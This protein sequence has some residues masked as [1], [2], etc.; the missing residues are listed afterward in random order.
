[1]ILM[2]LYRFYYFIKGTDRFRRFESSHNLMLLSTFI[3]KNDCYQILYAWTTNKKHARLFKE[4]RTED[5]VCDA[6][7]IDETNQD[8]LEEFNSKR[9]EQLIEIHRFFHY[10]E[11]KKESFVEFPVTIGEANSVE[12]F[13]MEVIGERVMN[14]CK[15]PYLILKDEYIQ[16]LELFLYTSFYGVYWSDDNGLED[17]TSYNL[18]YDCT[19]PSGFSVSRILS[20]CDVFNVFTNVYEDM[21]RKKVTL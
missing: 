5:L 8:L 14:V 19:T 9:R 6:I 13:L 16:A 4:K 7:K 10:D 3:E 12:D 18:G 15:T 2:K 11:N 21:I 17:L 1:M 20:K